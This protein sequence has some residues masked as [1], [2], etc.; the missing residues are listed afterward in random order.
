M[1]PLQG[2]NASSDSEKCQRILHLQY[3]AALEFKRWKDR[4]YKFH[5]IA[6]RTRP[7]TVLFSS[8]KIFYLYK[9]LF[10]SS[11]HKDKQYSHAESTNSNNF[12]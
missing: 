3:E 6:N 10:L 5:S 4:H 7:C 1:Q 9:K 11:F 8:L 2:K 12:W